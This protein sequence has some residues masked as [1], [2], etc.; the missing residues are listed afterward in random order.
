MI[1]DMT[2][3]PLPTPVAHNPPAIPV[4]GMLVGAM[5]ELNICL[6][7]VKCALAPESRTR[8]VST[9]F[10]WSSMALVAEWKWK[11][12]AVEA[13]TPVAGAGRGP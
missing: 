12:E 6:S 2:T 4:I 13:R 7:L 9:T 8:T 5:G 11:A 1:P 3:L 10:Q